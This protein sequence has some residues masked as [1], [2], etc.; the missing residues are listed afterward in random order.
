MSV[1]TSGDVMAI[2]LS[3]TTSS[4]KANAVASPM[5]VPPPVTTTFLPV[6]NSLGLVREMNGNGLECQVLVEETRIKV[7]KGFKRQ[8]KL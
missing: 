2:L 3:D 7:L 1:P 6:T 5:P 4:A 8:E